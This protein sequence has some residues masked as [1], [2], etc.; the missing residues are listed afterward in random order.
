[1]LNLARPEVI[2]YLFESLDKLLSDHHISFVKWDFNRPL[3][4]PG[5]PDAPIEQQREVYV[6]HVQ[7]FYDLVE[8]LRA[9]HPEVTWEVCASG[10]G[11][12]DLGALARFDQCWTSDNTD[13]FDR[14]HIQE[15]YSMAYA[16]KTMMAWASNATI[17]HHINNV[18]L[19][20]QYRFHS[21]MTGSLGLGE[22]LN[23]Y[24]E[25]Q[26]TEVAALVA[27]Y[28]AIRPIVQ[29]GLLY[30]LISPRSNDLT[31]VQYVSRDRREAVLFVFFH[32]QHWWRTAIRLYLRGLEPALRYQIEGLE[33]HDQ[34][35]S[36][37]SL[38]SLGLKPTLQGHFSSLV[39]K[40]RAI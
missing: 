15:G 37:Q 8:R 16:P 2:V 33:G 14:L 39:I 5:W 28:K 24:T 31:A 10:G 12:A 34:P 40:L 21:A 36:G 6:R 4:E 17:F 30:R 18:A 3:T 35:V 27:E 23:H 29:E 11:R 13:P 25:A 19:N 32:S 38:M 9:K 20:L 26:M 1:M 22:D 7:A